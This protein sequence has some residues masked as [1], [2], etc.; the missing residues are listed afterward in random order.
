MPLAPER[1]TLKLEL[2]GLQSS[3]KSRLAQVRAKIEKDSEEAKAALVPT[4]FYKRGFRI[5]RK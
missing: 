5:S 2:R 4:P 1:Q 3:K